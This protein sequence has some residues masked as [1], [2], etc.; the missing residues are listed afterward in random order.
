M[1]TRKNIKRRKKKKLTPI[2]LAII[3]MSLVVAFSIFVMCRQARILEREKIEQQEKDFLRQYSKYFDLDIEYYNDVPD[4]ILYKSEKSKNFYSFKEN[5]RHFNH[6]LELAEDE[7]YRGKAGDP[8]YSCFSYDNIDEIKNDRENAYIIFDYQDEEKRDN[9]LVLAYKLE[10]EES[11][12][13]KNLNYYS[14]MKFKVNGEDVSFER[15]YER[16]LEENFISIST[17]AEFKNI[18]MDKN[19]KLINDLDFENK[20]VILDFVYK[21]I[22]DG[23]GHSLKNIKITDEN[24]EKWGKVEYRG[25][26]T[27]N[28]GIIRNLKIEDINIDIKNEKFNIK[29][30]GVFVGKN[31]GAIRN[32]SLESGTINAENGNFAGIAYF[33]SFGE[34]TNCTNK[35]NINGANAGIVSEARITDIENCINEGNLTGQNVNGITSSCSGMI[36]N[37]KN[38]GELRSK[39]QSFGI[40]KISTEGIIDSSNSGM[41]YSENGLAAGIVGFA[42]N[43]LSGCV[44]SG[45]IE[46]VGEVAGIAIVAGEDYS[47]SIENCRNSGR[48]ILKEKDDLGYSTYSCIAGIVCEVLYGDIKSCINEGMLIYDLTSGLSFG[49][50]IARRTESVISDFSLD[51]IESIDMDSILDGTSKE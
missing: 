37:C 34:I 12:I 51:K 25:I 27:Q 42:E 22:L 29:N 6:L 26:I 41:I 32:C 33:S 35:V 5:S 14:F 45:E 11:L 1:G 9:N 30:F 50:I 23:N 16:I 8:T 15:K 48:I 13:Y 4:R 36:V 40:A 38:T 2:D 43:K 10:N 21:G 3:C 44:N 49:D 18:E 39:Y 20:P 19:Y 46:G 7:I 17:V 24:I 47:I 31:L 28:E